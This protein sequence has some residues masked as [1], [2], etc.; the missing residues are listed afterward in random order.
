MDKGQR[1]FNTDSVVELV[2][3]DTLICQVSYKGS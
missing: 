3:Q 1:C 2:A